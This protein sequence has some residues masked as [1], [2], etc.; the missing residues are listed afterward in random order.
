MEEGFFYVDETFLWGGRVF[1][2]I[3]VA[4]SISRERG[5]VFCRVSKALSDNHGGFA[6]GVIPAF[7]GKGELAGLPSLLLLPFKKL[8]GFCFCICFFIFSAKYLFGVSSYG[9]SCKCIIVQ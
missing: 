4:R 9:A 8:N 6:S 7:I 2:K 1:K 5:V 3:L